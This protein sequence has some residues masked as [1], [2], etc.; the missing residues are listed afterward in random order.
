MGDTWAP[1]AFFAP[2]YDSEDG[3]SGVS[4][5]WVVKNMGMKNVKVTYHAQACISKALA[6]AAQVVGDRE[7]ETVLVIRATGNLEGA[8]HVTDDTTAA[9]PLQWVNP[10]SWALIPQTAFTFNDYC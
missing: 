8:Y 3:L 9:G 7:A 1:N 6:A 10:W 5:D 2:P 4:A